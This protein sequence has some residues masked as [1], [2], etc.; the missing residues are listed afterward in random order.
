M[1]GAVFSAGSSGGVVSLTI[2]CSSRAGTR[3]RGVCAKAGTAS[4]VSNKRPVLFKKPFMADG[5]F[6]DMVGGRNRAGG[7][8]QGA[9]ADGE[10][11]D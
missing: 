2:A 4:A 11:H 7:K 1:R 3:S 8:K 9:A 5:L 6:N 10:K